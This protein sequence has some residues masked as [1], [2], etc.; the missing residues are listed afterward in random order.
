MIKIT[1]IRGII[2]PIINNNEANIMRTTINHIFEKIIVH[3]IN[4]CT[5]YI[6]NYWV[7]TNNTNMALKEQIINSINNNIILLLKQ[8][9]LQFKDLYNKTQLK[10]NHFNQFIVHMNKLIKCLLDMVEHIY[11]VHDNIKLIQFIVHNMIDIVFNDTSLNNCITSQILEIEPIKKLFTY[12]DSCYVLYNISDI[13]NHNDVPLISKKDYM[14]VDGKIYYNGGTKLLNI[15]HKCI[16]SPWA[17]TTYMYYYV[18]SSDYKK[19]VLYDIID[20]VMYNSYKQKNNM[21]VQVDTNIQAMYDFKDMV[22]YLKKW[23]EQYKFMCRTTYYRFKFNAT[24]PIFNKFK[25]TMLT[26][27]TDILMCRDV[28]VIT[29]FFDSYGEEIHYIINKISNTTVVLIS[30]FPGDIDICLVYLNILYNFGRKF[31]NYIIEQMISVNVK[32]RFDTTQK[33]DLLVNHIHEYICGSDIEKNVDFYF[34]IGSCL[35]NCDEFVALLTQKLIERYVYQDH[36]NYER[37]NNIHMK[38]KNIFVNYAEVLYPYNVVMNDIANGINVNGIN[39]ICTTPHL[40]KMNYM[41]GNVEDI[42]NEQ[43]FDIFNGVNFDYKLKF[44]NRHLIYY[45]HMGMIDAHV[46]GI[47]VIMLPFHMLILELFIEPN[48]MLTK[49]DI[50]TKLKNVNYDDDIKYKIIDSIV[51]GQLL[52]Q[53]DNYYLVNTN[54]MATHVNLIDIFNC[55]NMVQNETIIHEIVHNLAHDRIDIIKVNINHF[56]KIK[57]HTENELYKT[58]RHNIKIFN[59]SEELFTTALTS[60][61]K[62]EYIKMDKNNVIKLMY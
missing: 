33:I 6:F 51:L 38:L 24:D 59:V 11:N 21:Q 9:Q 12:L 43:C 7:F 8:R 42:V 62:N 34:Y 31:N 61:I 53:K 32:I 58:V 49:N 17:E 3:D 23:E 1:D 5:S 28:H 2:M 57:S 30:C 14:C 19:N 36:F 37:E 10:V 54:I 60:M 16:S 13:H 18:K 40:W 46:N 25:Q 15:I 55:I 50:I 29:N 56:V 48:V 44:P 41:M 39:V 45:P 26:A 20:N 35:A 27:F 22:T 4:E 52:V 47:H